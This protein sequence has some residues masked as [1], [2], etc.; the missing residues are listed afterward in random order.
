MGELL[1]IGKSGLL[2]RAKNRPVTIKRGYSIVGDPGGGKL[3]FLMTQSVEAIVGPAGDPKQ[4][5]LKG[6]VKGQFRIGFPTAK[7][8][9][10]EIRPEVILAEPAIVDPG[11]LP[12]H[13]GGHRQ[14]RFGLLVGLQQLFFPH[15]SLANGLG[16]GIRRSRILEQDE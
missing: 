1:G 10:L 12:L 6:V 11:R 4:L 15:P 7:A 2:R 3:V 9:G 16:S 8:T 13:L 5:N 14:A